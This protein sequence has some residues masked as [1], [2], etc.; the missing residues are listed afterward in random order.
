MPDAPEPTL[1][2]PLTEEEEALL[3]RCYRIKEITDDEIVFPVTAN[4]TWLAVLFTLLWFIMVGGFLVGRW[5][6]LPSSAPS[7]AWMILGVVPT[8]G[9]IWLAGW[10]R[11]LLTLGRGTRTMVVDLGDGAWTIQLPQGRSPAS[12]DF[13]TA[14]IPVRTSADPVELVN[15][16]EVL[17][18]FS[19]LSLSAPVDVTALGLLQECGADVVGYDSEE[20]SLANLTSAR[21][22]FIIAGL[23]MLHVPVLWPMVSAIVSMISGGNR[24]PFDAP[25]GAATVLALMAALG[26]ALIVWDG[27]QSSVA[28]FRRG[29]REVAMFHRG[30]TRTYDVHEDAVGTYSGGD[31]SE[32]VIV[33]PVYS[34]APLG[35]TAPLLAGFLRRH[36]APLKKKRPT[37]DVPTPDT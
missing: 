30:A 29:K 5:Q 8:Y 23:T 16:A 25:L 17:E 14:S 20:V 31:A 3:R 28:T 18:R 32:T 33:R 1:P 36:L 2:P 4:A 11:V 12:W 27:R 24:D 7:F 34:F 13:P 15:A 22:F 35:D 19:G 6:F 26:P 9:L 21:A 10:R 37:T